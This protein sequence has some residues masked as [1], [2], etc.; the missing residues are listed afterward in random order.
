MWALVTG[1]TSGIGAEFTKLLAKEHYNIILV[2]RDE[3]RLKKSA[4]ELEKEFGVTTEI[5]VAD[6]SVENEI[7]L[8]E[9]AC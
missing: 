1:A 3:I 4:Q 9:N 5:I 2:A 8:V 7:V 6:L